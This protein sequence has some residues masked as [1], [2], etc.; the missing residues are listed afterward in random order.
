MAL[1]EKIK[2]NKWRLGAALILLG[3]ILYTLYH[4]FAASPGSLM[5]TPVRSITDL[6]VIKG[7][8]YLFR[9]EEVIA[10]PGSGVVELLCENGSKVGKNAPVAN[11]WSGYTAQTAEYAQPILEQIDR[12]IKILEDSTVKGTLADADG[13]R[14]EADGIYAELMRAKNAGKW[15]DLSQ[16][17]DRMLVFLNRYGSLTGTNAGFAEV[18]SQLRTERGKILSGQMQTVTNDR[19]SGSFYDRGHVDGREGIFTAKALEALTPAG[20]TEL[21]S[22]PAQDPSGTTLVGKMVYGYTWYL[23]VE[24]AP[25]DA[26]PAVGDVCTVRFPRLEGNTL[27]MTCE[28]SETDGDGRCLVVLSSGENPAWFDYARAQTLEIQTGSVQGLYVPN[29]ALVTLDGVEGVYI[30]RDSTVR[31]RRVEVIRR[32]DGY[33]VAAIHE[34]DEHYLALYDILITAGNDLYEGK[35]Y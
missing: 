35:V 31:F 28:K 27:D 15:S 13:Y 16:L 18:L 23:A 22:M 5:T 34:N 6:Y 17:G 25:G 1:L 24:L 4:V 19:S 14:R 26:I 3:L 7:T 2:Q 20:L 29:S 30:L 33:C 21:A 32:G 11:L 9:D 8:G 10:S 12:M